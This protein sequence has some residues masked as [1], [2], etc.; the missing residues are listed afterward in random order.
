MKFLIAY[1]LEWLLYLRIAFRCGWE[2][3][4]ACGQYLFNRKICN[5]TTELIV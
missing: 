2:I 1:I 5:C 4:E 3:L